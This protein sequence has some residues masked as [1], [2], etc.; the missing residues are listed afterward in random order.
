MAWTPRPAEITALLSQPGPARYQYFLAKAA[1]QETIWSLW[2]EEGWALAGDD[3]GRQLVPV[4]P[5]E[6]YAQACNARAWAGYEPKAI[7]MDAWLA[8]WI[9]GMTRDGRLVAVFPT[10]NDR[11]V[12]VEPTQLEADLRAKL[13]EF[14]E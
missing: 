3:Q 12:V 14:D 13:A 5:H 7:E 10:P 1:D 11:G 9:P 8:R 4:W 2:Q 6:K